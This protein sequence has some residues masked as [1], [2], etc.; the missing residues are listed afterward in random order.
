MKIFTDRGVYVQKNDL[1]ILFELGNYVPKSIIDKFW[2]CEAVVI[3]D[4]NRYDF[5][6]FDREDEV[7]FFRSII[8]FLDFDDVKDLSIQELIEM[9]QSLAEKRNGIA[10]S[11]NAMNEVDRRSNIGLLLDCEVLDFQ[12]HSLSDFIL[13]K[14]GKI[15]M[16]FPPDVDCPPQFAPKKI[17]RQLVRTLFGNIKR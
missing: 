15:K 5:V 6:F 8:C 2:N 17:F 9:G 4:E 3:T 12:M 10:A 7:Q 13:Y 16:N 11:F 1:Q 14:K